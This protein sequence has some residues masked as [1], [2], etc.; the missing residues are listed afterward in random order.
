MIIDREDGTPAGDGVDDQGE[1]FKIDTVLDQVA[2]KFAVKNGC[3]TGSET[4]VFEINSVTGDTIINSNTTIINGTLSLQGSCGGTTGE[5]PSPDPSLDDKLTIKNDEGP[6][7]DVNMCNGD[8]SVGSTVGTVFAIGGY[9]SG[10]PIAHTKGTSVVHGYRFDKQTLNAVNGPISQVSVGFTLDDWNIPIDDKT[11][12]QKGDLV[13]IYSTTQAEIILLTD[14]PYESSGQDYLPTI[15][16]AEYPASQYPN[17]G[18]GAEGSG[19]QNWSA[20]A[21]VVKLRKY[22]YTTTLIDDIPATGRTA[23]EAPNTNANK[24]R[25][26]L[27][28]SRLVGNKLDTSHFLRIVTGNSQEWFWADSIDGNNSSY[29]V[30]IAKGTQS[31]A[32]AV[33]GELT[34]FFGGGST[35]IFDEV[36]I[37]SGEFRIWGSDGETLLFNISNDDDHPADGAVLDPKTGKNGLWIKGGGTFL[38]D[39]RVQTDTCEANGVCTNDDVFRVF[40]EQG[41][42]NMGEQLY[43]KGKVVTTDVGDADLAVLHIDNMGGAGTGGTVGPRDFKIYQDCS[44]DAFGISRYF[45]RNGGRRYTYVEQ[46]LTGLGQ[47]QTNPLQPNNNYLLNN[48]AGTNMVLYLPDY[49]ETGDMIRFV[50]V[51]GNLTYNTNLVL[52]ALKVNNQSTAIQGDI[53]GSKIQAG[54]G[55]LTTAWDSGELIVQTRNAS[56]GLIYVGPTDAAGDPN[57]TSIPSNLRGWW[58]TE[59]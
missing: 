33:T 22:G 1:V 9:W 6:V 26:R 30:R 8:M 18:R 28:D 51:S 56:F 32:Q 31:A 10:T 29:G 41:N 23:V 39:L 54:S 42:V 36:N 12:F 19:K 17:G 59:L 7:W 37:Y 50:E 47:T 24:I 43:I 15:Y 44:I 52:R 34:N 14:D 38:D 5:Y 2:K 45:T 4:T 48:P 57:A 11:A 3:D 13:L 25:L 58:L 46:S 21:T 40:N 27:K 20:G 53:S 16:N 49:A 35:T 55:T